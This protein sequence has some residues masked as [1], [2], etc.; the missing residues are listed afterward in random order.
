MLPEPRTAT[1]KP[2]RL[3][4]RSPKASAL[5]RIK[6]LPLL[7]AARSMLELLV[8]LGRGK[9][10]RS[11]EFVETMVES[12]FRSNLAG[13]GATRNFEETY[14]VQHARRVLRQLYVVGLV[15]WVH[16]LPGGTFPRGETPDEDGG[17]RSAG[18]HGGN[19]YEVNMDALL[20]VGP[21]WTPAVRLVEEPPATV[22]SD[23]EEG[24]EDPEPD[25]D[26]LITCA[27]P[28]VITSD[29]SS[30]SPTPSA[31]SLDPE[32]PA[33]RSMTTADAGSSRELVAP[34]QLE[35]KPQPPSPARERPADAG[36][37]RSARAPQQPTSP[38]APRART[39]R[40]T[41]TLEGNEEQGG[42]RTLAPAVAATMLD[43]LFGP[44]WRTRG[45][46]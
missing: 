32:R 19:V 45:G 33:S 36:S 1:G 31:L 39:A 4:S 16:V 7:P 11:W 28:R 8:H 3:Y 17:G 21:V 27:Q 29:H 22:D 44:N 37:E 26:R 43:A 15:R 10:C 25:G 6:F 18:N 40:S 13:Q 41:E 24:A 2:L 30:E 12:L 20:G 35:A 38:Y 46:T 42:C 9:R 23:V 34:S 5:A 14:S